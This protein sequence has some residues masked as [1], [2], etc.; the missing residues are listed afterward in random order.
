MRRRQGMPGGRLASDIP[1]ELRRALATDLR[2]LSPRIPEALAEITV[3]LYLVG[4]EGTIRWLNAA[5]SNSSVIAWASTTPSSLPVT[6]ARRLTSGSP[7]RFSA[8][9]ARRPTR[10][11]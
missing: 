5:A 3:P 11:P 10:A 9:R 4:R 8:A 7:G 6:H 2:K 1:T